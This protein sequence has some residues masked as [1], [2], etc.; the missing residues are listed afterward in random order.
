MIRLSDLSVK[1]KLLLLIGV[2]MLIALAVF[3]VVV[4]IFL[5]VRASNRYRAEL[6]RGE[7]YFHEAQKCLMGYQG[8]QKVEAS[9]AFFA[10]LRAYLDSGY[11]IC[12]A[13]R[14]GE[15][16]QQDTATG[17]ELFTLVD[18][19]NWCKARYWALDDE[20]TPLAP[21]VLDVLESDGQNQSR[22]VRR[23]QE[24]RL[25]AT[26]SDMLR[27]PERIIRAMEQLRGFAAEFP[28]QAQA[29]VEPYITMH[30]EMLT[31]NNAYFAHVQTVDNLL[32]Q[33]ISSLVATRMAREELVEK[34][35]YW[36]NMTVVLGVFVL[37][38]VGTTVATWFA[39]RMVSSLSRCLSGMAELANGNI[40]VQFAAKDI[41]G[42]DE[43]KQLMRG[44]VTLRDKLRIVI[45][46][47]V[48]GANSISI[49]SEQLNQLS[50]G[51]AN[52]NN[53][54]SAT[55]EEVTSSMEE[56][57][58]NIE[59]NSSKAQETN[60]LASDM[61]RQIEQVAQHA[62]TSAEKGHAIASRVGVIGEI[63]SQTNILALNAAVEAAR[64][65]EQGRG[66]SVVASEVR[67]LAERS[68]A[69][70]EE[71]TGLTEESRRIAEESGKLI[72][73]V[74]P[75]VG[76]TTNLVHEISD[77]S[78][79][80]Q[81]G[82]EQINTALQSLNSTVQENATAAEEMANSSQ[83]LSAQAEKLR[84]VVWQFRL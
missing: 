3:A 14:L 39:R 18:T 28:A 81:A 44:L 63:A 38:V 77:S 46:K 8:E 19:M 78:S 45:N 60:R 25:Q 73:A 17:T 82:A 26:L 4:S 43:F 34:Q 62:S 33:T 61:Q 58:S 35:I 83:Q 37:L 51:V 64:A 6:L 59:M 52:A 30:D 66:F 70:A 49:A 16:D 53:Q 32:D 7:V 55:S 22:N 21:K 68:K 84:E 20:V 5:N 67:K 31:Y 10:Q 54:Q 9:N 11:K 1:R 80:Q 36:A 65:G 40:G 29:L 50:E 15:K 41:E 24:F 75:S 42:R 47:I 27:E 23:F 57:V 56:M 76:K 12:Q 79:E 2:E 13:L 48:E 71:I 74:L 69:A 72:A